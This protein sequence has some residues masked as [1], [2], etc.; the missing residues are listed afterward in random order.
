[1]P[2]LMNK[3]DKLLA[4]VLTALLCT[5]P[6]SPPLAASSVIQRCKSPDGALIYTDKACVALEA[7]ATPMSRELRNRIASEAAHERSQSL[8]QTG[9]P[10][11]DP[12]TPPPN[13]VRTS[14]RSAAAGC[15]RT[16]TQLEMD[17]QG[18]L[19]LGDVNRLAESYHWTGMSTRQGRQTMERLQHLIG[20]QVVDSQYF[21][22][23]ISSAGSDWPATA[24][25]PMGGLASATGLG[26][27][28]GVLQLVLRDDSS[29]TSIIDFDVE[30]YSGCYFVSF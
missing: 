26:G 6:L 15:A 7:R 24:I 13:A 30:R 14:R 19:A 18:S 22:A 10:V 1:M 16:P 8:S 27:S 9:F 29:N 28:A 11:S 2:I 20:R 12:R 5:L 17:L 4:A 25:A 3:L 21:N 23:S